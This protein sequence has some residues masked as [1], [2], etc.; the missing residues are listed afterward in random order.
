MDGRASQ[1]CAHVCAQGERTNRS[2][3][4]GSLTVATESLLKAFMVRNRMQ[5]PRK[6]VVYRDGVSDGQFQEI[7][8]K[9][10]PAIKDGMAL[11]GCPDI[12]ICIVVCQK[13]HNTRVVF[14]ESEDGGTKYVNPC[15][16]LVIDN[17]GGGSSITHAKY[18]EFYLT[19]HI[20]IQ[21]TS[22]P[23]K[24]TLIYDEIG[25]KVGFVLY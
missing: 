1:Y 12:K 4:I 19:S 5:W 14:E 23:T 17:A 10:L 8:N 15:P 3:V 11:V 18:N 7:L 21:G 2:E 16:G 20:A 6:I 9:E 24:Y 13:R 22:K 25:L